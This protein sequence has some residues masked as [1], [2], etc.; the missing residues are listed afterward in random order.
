MTTPTTISL[1]AL[2]TADTSYR[3]RYWN[4]DRNPLL[5]SVK[6]HGIRTPLIA[7]K[8]DGS[9]QLIQ[10]FRRLE[11]ARE[12]GL[13][14]VPVVLSDAD[15][16]ENLKASL[17]DNRVQG[18]FNIYEQANAMAVAG[19]LGVR[20]SEIVEDIL[21]LLGLHAHKNVYDDYR[22]FTR[23]PRP[24]I[25]FFVE[26]ETPVSRTRVFQQLSD[27]GLAVALEVL[28]TFSPGINV[29][30]ELLTN[31]HEISR[32]DD[33]P[34]DEIYRRLDIEE[35]LEEAG[36]PHIALG[37]IRRKLHEHRYPMLSESNA[38][39]DEL[40]GS[41]ELAHCRNIHWDN[42]LESR[43]IHVTFHWDTVAEA[44]ESVQS[45]LRDQ[46]KKLLN[47]IFDDV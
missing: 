23:L 30:D 39:I 44:E 14:T 37:E 34:V 29:L 36:Q 13:K 20:E 45:I 28:H 33:L 5:R 17:I 35:I 25:E 38:R 1:D 19:D 6:M 42:T 3:Y 9:L 40:T 2:D 41:L 32:R 26:K 7:G 27:A 11:C 24:L 15:P 43:G 21:P 4:Y 22:G 47:K 10:G 12:L 8:H 46:N 16:L 18:E 31:L